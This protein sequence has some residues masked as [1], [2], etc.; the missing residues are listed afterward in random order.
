M[1]VG[2]ITDVGLIRENNQDSMFV[3]KNKDFPLFVIADGMGGHNSGE[4]ASSMAVDIV[5]ENLILQM[6]KLTSEKDIKGLLEKAVLD[7][8][9]KIYDKSKENEIYNRMG[10]TIIL[11]YIYKSK[12]YLAHVGDSRAYIVGENM[13]QITEDHSLVYELVK[14]G[15][16]TKEE[17]LH[18]PQKNMI[19]RAVGTSDELDVDI[20]VLPYKNGDI[21]VLC[22]DGLSNMVLEEELLNTFKGEDD[23]CKAVDKLVLRAKENGGKDN[24]SV[25]AIKFI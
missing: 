8:N 14:N 6:E 1:I 16:I 12:I 7:A 10:T 24:I 25:I 3:S 9:E 5:K 23:M 20:H 19:T 17:A 4:V 15:S 21:L 2:A 18:H 11:A 22:S 13:N